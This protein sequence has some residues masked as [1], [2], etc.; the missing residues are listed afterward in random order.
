MARRP[1]GPLWGARYCG[2]AAER[3]VHDLDN[4]RPNCR[5]DEILAAGRAVPFNY[6]PAARL[7]GFDNCAY[8]IGG[9]RRQRRA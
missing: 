6:L 9:S 2:N 3:A 7:A 4:E 5:I 8:C 1:G